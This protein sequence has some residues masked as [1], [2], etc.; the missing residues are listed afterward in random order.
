MLPRGGPSHVGQP[1]P[2]RQHFRETPHM[3]DINM[4]GVGIFA[5]YGAMGIG[6]CIAVGVIA[7]TLITRPRRRR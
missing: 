6:L 5:V 1:L 7:S 2:E 3:N 4:L